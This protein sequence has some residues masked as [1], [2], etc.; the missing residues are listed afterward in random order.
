V[1]EQFETKAR[2]EATVRGDGWNAEDVMV[3]IGAVGGLVLSGTK[4]PRD[5]PLSEWSEPLGG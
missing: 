4:V 5:L 1:T 2:A 3:V